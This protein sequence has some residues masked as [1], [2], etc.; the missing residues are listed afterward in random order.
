[1]PYISILS[2]S[3]KTTREVITHHYYSQ[4]AVKNYL[5]KHP[6]ATALV[7]KMNKFMGIYTAFVNIHT[8]LL[9]N[10]LE[11]VPNWWTLYAV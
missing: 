10:L 2:K 6:P 7:K 1:M 3:G 4:P 8:E 9:S 11:Q 5:N